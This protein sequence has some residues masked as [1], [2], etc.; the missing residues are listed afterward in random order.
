MKRL[1]TLIG[2]LAIV[3]LSADAASAQE[4]PRPRR[5]I[6]GRGEVESKGKQFHE[7]IFINGEDELNIRLVREGGCPGCRWQFV[8][9]CLQNGPV[10]PGEPTPDALCEGAT[11]GCPPHHI[12]YRVYLTRPP[13]PAEVVA[14]RCIGPRDVVPMVD[15]GEAAQDAFGKMKPEP[16][17]PATEHATVPLV[18]LATYLSVDGDTQLTNQLP[19]DF[20]TLN[21]T[22]R[23]D[24]RW[25]FGDGETLT[26]QQQGRAY[27]EG[28]DPRHA[29]SAPDAIMHWYRTPGAKTAT[30]TTTWTATY[31][32]TVNGVVS[33]PIPV[34][35]SITPPAQDL[36]IDV[37]EGRAVLYS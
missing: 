30:V 22:A 14:T 28:D 1:V 33:A 36:P 21:L 11:V 19:L 24:Y 17:K 13:G 32:V 15:A 8:P 6:E 31:T 23:P 16:A 10:A 35:G 18:N 4:R 27:R 7:V 34:A 29:P 25:D 37:H 12:R 26:T 3:A 20:V 5:P 2:I 9:T